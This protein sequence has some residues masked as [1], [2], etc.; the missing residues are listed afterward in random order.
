M[1]SESLKDLIL[2]LKL[3]KLS[4]QAIASLVGI[5]R[6]KFLIFD[7]LAYGVVRG[8]N[9]MLTPE[10]RAQAIAGVPAGLDLLN[11]LID[12]KKEPIR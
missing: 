12:E 3:L 11:E 6:D 5:P 8:I 9:P 2:Q 10:E 4:Q 7:S 1:K